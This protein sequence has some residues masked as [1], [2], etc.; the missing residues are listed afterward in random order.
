MERWPGQ[1]RGG[2]GSRWET[3]SC[4]S[5]PADL[6]S[7]HR[8]SERRSSA[9]EEV[10]GEADDWFFAAG[11]HVVVATT[12][13]FAA[14][15]EAAAVMVAVCAVSLL[16]FHQARPPDDAALLVYAPL[17]FLIWAT[18][19]TGVGGVTTTIAIVAYLSITGTLQS[20][21]PFAPAGPERS[22]L[23]LQIFLIVT[24]STL[25]LLAAALAEL[26]RARAV[27]VRREARL[28]LALR[29]AHMG[30]W[31]WDM[32]SDRIS[33]RL[34]AHSGEIVSQSTDSVDR[35]LERVHSNDRHRL[36][37]AMRVAREKGGAGEMECRFTLRRAAALDTRARQGAARR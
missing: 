24:A 5:L 12:Y 25:M 19:R 16:V 11:R 14:A 31:E 21:G 37:A 1:L 6:L 22:V 13:C 26:H 28:D 10:A 2:P 3:G 20:T 7:A 30:A 8:R 35:L 9:F 32:L 29:A 15:V 18:L 34:A 17:P 36:V 27:A 4:P 33:W 23:S